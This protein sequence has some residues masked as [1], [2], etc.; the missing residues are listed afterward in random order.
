M[1]NSDA[2]GAFGHNGGIQMS[3]EH[4]LLDQLGSCAKKTILDTEDD[5]RRK[6]AELR[7]KSPRFESW[8]H[9]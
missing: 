8:P 3:T 4:L 5:R 2:V 6:N 1:G 7:G 9:H